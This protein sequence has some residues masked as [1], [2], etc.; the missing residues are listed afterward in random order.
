MKINNLTRKRLDELHCLLDDSKVEVTSEIKASIKNNIN[1]YQLDIKKLENNFD[2]EKDKLLL[3]SKH[4]NEVM[5]IRKQ[6]S[7][8]RIGFSFLLLLITVL[9]VNNIYSFRMS[10]KYYFLM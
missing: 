5:D 4:T 7:V 6:F 8:S 2:T 10:Y 1:K 9:I 3:F